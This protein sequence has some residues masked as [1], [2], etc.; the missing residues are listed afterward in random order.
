M[1]K[2]TYYMEKETYY[3]LNDKKRPKEYRS[4]QKHKNTP[5]LFCRGLSIPTAN[6]L[7]RKRTKNTHY[8]KETIHPSLE[9]VWYEP[10]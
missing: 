4:S 3:T 5:I 2:E 1:T 8:D 6:L 9:R 7:T 10:H